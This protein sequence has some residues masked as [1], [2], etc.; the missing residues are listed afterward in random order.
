MIIEKKPQKS[1]PKQSTKICPSPVK[2]CH[3]LSSTF[4]KEIV[5]K[6][7]PIQSLLNKGRNFGRMTKI[8]W[9]EDDEGWLDAISFDFDKTNQF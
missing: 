3:K 1:A 5:T 2:F 4:K 7:Y 9:F 8:C 6:Q